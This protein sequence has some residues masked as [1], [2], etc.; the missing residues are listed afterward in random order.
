MYLVFVIVSLPCLQILG[1]KKKKS[2]RNETLVSNL[3]LNIH[4]PLGAFLYCA[5]FNV[6]NA[7]LTGDCLYCKPISCCFKLSFI[8]VSSYFRD[9]HLFKTGS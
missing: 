9:L 5:K 3:L 8:V 2:A 1:K 4:M 6:I 7:I